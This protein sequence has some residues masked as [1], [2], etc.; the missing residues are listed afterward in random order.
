L[1]SFEQGILFHPQRGRRNLEKQ[2]SVASYWLGLASLIIAVVFRV[3]AMAG[4]AVWNSSPG[5]VAVSYLTFFHGAEGFL[6]LSI[7]SSAIVWYKLPR[8]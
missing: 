1:L 4:F 7:A 2:L 3:L 6:L 5:T 8:G